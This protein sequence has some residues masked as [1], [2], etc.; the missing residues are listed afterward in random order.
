VE[1][2]GVVGGLWGRH[3]EPSLPEAQLRKI[4]FVY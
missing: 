4:T 1:Q 3:L 2:A